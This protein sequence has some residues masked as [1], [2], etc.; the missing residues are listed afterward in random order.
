MDKK[1]ATKLLVNELVKASGQKFVTDTAHKKHL[2]E[3]ALSYHSVSHEE[4]FS[5][6]SEIYWPY[7]NG[8]LFSRDNYETNTQDY[9]KK[10]VEHCTKVSDANYVFVEHTENL[11]FS[12]S[13]SMLHYVDTFS[14]FSLIGGEEVEEL[15][16]KFYKDVS[17]EIVRAME[18]LNIPNFA[19]LYKS[20]KEKED[21]QFLHYN[22]PPDDFFE[23]V[24]NLPYEDQNIS[25]N[26]QFIRENCHKVDY[27]EVLVKEYSNGKHFKDYFNCLRRYDQTILLDSLKNVKERSPVNDSFLWSQGFKELQLDH[28]ELYK[29][30]N[31]GFTDYFLNRKV[32]E[33]KVI[34]NDI[35]GCDFV[36][37]EV[38]KWLNENY[39]E[40]IR[41]VGFNG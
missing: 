11:S 14:F 4:P 28:L 19:K 21:W 30:N 32:D 1:K 6:K 26:M 33:Q 20:Y 13:Y 24:F 3:N 25:T 17:V 37:E 39:S 22:S 16:K 2:L 35:M 5:F 31:Q 41:E 36:N 15:K 7:G 38:I 8:K 12:D 18:I 34:L 9:R 40:L 27:I 29:G 10:L 23:F